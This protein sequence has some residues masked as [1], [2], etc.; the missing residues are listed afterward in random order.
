MLKKI[1]NYIRGLSSKLSK[2]EQNSKDKA[3]KNKRDCEP[4]DAI[5]PMW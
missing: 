4:P 2:K 1:I 3:D 5:Y